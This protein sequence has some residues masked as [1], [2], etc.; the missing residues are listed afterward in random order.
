MK[1][2]V[3]SGVIAIILLVALLV[4]GGIP[5]YIGI[6]LIS[7]Q[8]YREMIN[9]K[10]FS[11]VPFLIKIFGAILTLLL[12]ISAAY[13]NS[14][15]FGLSYKALAVLAIVTITPSVIIKEYK[16]MDAI[17]LFGAITFISLAFSCFII[18]VCQSKL[19]FTYLI[20]ITIITDTFAMLFGMLIGKHKLIPRV[21][22]NKT[23]EGSVGGSLLAT[24]IAVIFYAN[25]IG[26]VKLYVIIPITLIFS[27]IGQFGDLIFSLIKRENDIKDF[28]NIIPGHGGILDRLD[29][30]I[31]VIIAYV[32]FFSMI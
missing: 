7:L 16:V 9:L 13:N 26:N 10:S 19:L 1:Q 30:I 18:V 5:F 8:A 22:P 24:I 28:S 14:F 2:R 6:A 29:S 31:L 15:L 17:M 20:L 4:I 12:V 27:I 23:I 11:N 21:S 3:I 25:L 32:L